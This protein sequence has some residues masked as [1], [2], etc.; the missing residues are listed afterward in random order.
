MTPEA[1]D[2]DDLRTRML[3]EGYAR[4]RNWCDAATLS[5]YTHGFTAAIDRLQQLN[6]P[7]QCL[8]LFVQPWECI[9]RL[10]AALGPV[11][12]TQLIHDF[13]IF[14]VRPGGRGWD[15]H[16]DRGGPGSKIGFDR[17]SGLPLYN[18][19]WMALTDASPETSCMYVLPAGKDPEYRCELEAT[20]EQQREQMNL[21][22]ITATRLQS[23]RA[24][25]A[26][27]GDVLVWSHRLI[28]WGSEHAGASD[29]PRQTLSFAMADP[30]FE[31]SLLRSTAGLPDGD[32][33]M[34][35]LPTFDTR[36]L[37]VAYTCVAYHHG[38]PVPAE[39]LPPLLEALSRA[40]NLLSDHALRGAD[41]QNNLAS[42]HTEHSVGV[43]SSSA[44]LVTAIEVVARYVANERRLPLIPTLA[45]LACV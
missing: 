9:Q 27:A 10:C 20:E 6:L 7:A 40:T 33:E 26:Q 23:V 29:A 41:L 1:L 15:V 11:Y 8:M 2:A 39:L 30:R 3:G 13:Y 43:G 4:V 22:V 16:R 37:L 18:T 35:T 36:L 34:Q 24:L 45:R 32:L 44:R 21:H 28:H 12:K 42:I 38:A 17:E 25:P 31:G 5:G 19:I 14:N